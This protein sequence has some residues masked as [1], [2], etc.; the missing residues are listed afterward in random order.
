LTDFEKG[1]FG[2]YLRGKYKHEA[3]ALSLIKHEAAEKAL[4]GMYIRRTKFNEDIWSM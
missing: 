4:Y 2:N 1:C 3:T